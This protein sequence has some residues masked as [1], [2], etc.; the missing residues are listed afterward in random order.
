MN[1]VGFIKNTTT[2]DTM[3][4][5]YSWELIGGFKSLDVVLPVR[6]AEET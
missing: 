2:K 5:C 6:S 3:S 1:S 4:L